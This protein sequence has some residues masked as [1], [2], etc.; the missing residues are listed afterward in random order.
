MVEIK[1][2]KKSCHVT[3]NGNKLDISAEMVLSFITLAE[4][5]AEAT[6]YDKEFAAKMIYQTAVLTMAKDEDERKEKKQ[7]VKPGIGGGAK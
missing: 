1:T 3:C 5:M 4:T 7:A 2:E 6:G